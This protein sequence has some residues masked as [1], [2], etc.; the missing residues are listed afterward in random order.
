VPT[1][2]R[3][4][5]RIREMREAGHDTEAI[6]EALAVSRRSVQRI[7]QEERGNVSSL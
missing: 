3:Q 4:S 7:L 2:R 6:A 1:A 5:E